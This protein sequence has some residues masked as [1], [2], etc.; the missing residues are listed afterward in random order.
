M[1]IWKYDVFFVASLDPFRAIKLFN[2]EGFRAPIPQKTKILGCKIILVKTNKVLFT[3][4]QNPL[5]NSS[6]KF[7]VQTSVLGLGLDFV[8]PLSQQQEQQEEP[9]PKS[10][11]EFD[12]EDQVLYSSF[13]VGSNESF[14]IQTFLNL[15]PP[16]PGFQIYPNWNWNFFLTPTPYL[17]FSPIFH[18]FL[19]FPCCCYQ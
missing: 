8:F 6:P 14:R 4:N 13:F 7:K 15:D 9:P 5:S 1:K 18:I 19:G 11:L 3:S 12:T 2:L 16:S 10:K 17:G